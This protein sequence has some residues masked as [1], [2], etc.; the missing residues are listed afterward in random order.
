MDPAEASG[1]LKRSQSIIYKCD[2]T[3]ASYAATSSQGFAFKTGSKLPSYVFDP[4]QPNPQ[5][6]EQVDKCVERIKSTLKRPEKASTIRKSELGENQL[7]FSNEETMK[8]EIIDE[9]L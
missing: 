1:L 4:L 3:V 9:L 2:S 8:L 5:E 7:V 6:K